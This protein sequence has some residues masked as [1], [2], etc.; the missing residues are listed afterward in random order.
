MI[1]N[2]KA[3]SLI[4]LF[5]MILITT[6]L[7]YPLIQSLVKNIEINDML[8]QRRSST[9]ISG[10]TLSS[11]DKF[12]F[13]DLY[14]LLEKANTKNDFYIDINLDSCKDINAADL[15]LCT[16]LF[17]TVW[18]NLSL[19]SDEYRVIIYNFYLTDEA[20]NSLIDDPN[21]PSAVRD[22]ILITFELD[23]PV[24]LTAAQIDTNLSLLR[25]TVWIEYYQDPLSTMTLSGAIFD[26]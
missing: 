3:F 18:N 26:D 10:G 24:T 5:A 4:E 7:I 13:Q 21:V 17:N 11:F 23:H 8:Q 14:D 12:V 2:N 25:A 1:K 6:I 16:S 9:S 20:Y 19:E 15:T 22:E